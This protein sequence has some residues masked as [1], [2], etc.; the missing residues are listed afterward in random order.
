[1]SMPIAVEQLE[2]GDRVVLGFA[3]APAVVVVREITEGVTIRTL[4]GNRNGLPFELSVQ[5]GH[6]VD[7]AC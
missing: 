6:T 1:M 2:K 3:D 5:R 4:H 7:L